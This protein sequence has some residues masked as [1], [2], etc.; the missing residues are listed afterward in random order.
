ME[1]FPGH[2]LLP[3]NLAAGQVKAGVDPVQLYLRIAAGIPNGDAPLMPSFS[4]LSPE[5]IWALVGFLE[6]EVLPKGTLAE[7]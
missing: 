4:Y 2:E 3:A 7:R 5:E 6:A 1:D